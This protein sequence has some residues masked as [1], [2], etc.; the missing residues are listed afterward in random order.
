MEAEKKPS[1]LLAPYLQMVKVNSLPADR[2]VDVG[3]FVEADTVGPVDAA[4]VLVAAAERPA[5]TEKQ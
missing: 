4:A 1:N 3:S 2:A 5:I